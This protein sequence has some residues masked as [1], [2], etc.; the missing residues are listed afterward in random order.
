MR[1]EQLKKFLL[2]LVRGSP[3]FPLKTPELIMHFIVRLLTR[4]R[5]ELY[6]SVLFIF[7]LAHMS[8][9]MGSRR[10]EVE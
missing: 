10:S 7:P 6:F 2:Q 9:V 4:S 5:V 1:L 3:L 8:E